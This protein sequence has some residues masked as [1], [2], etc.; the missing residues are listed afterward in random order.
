MYQVKILLGTAALCCLIVVLVMLWN[1]K[2]LSLTFFEMKF[3]E[4]VLIIIS[5]LLAKDC[6]GIKKR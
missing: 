4:S 3:M 6:A 1:E 2:S 5:I